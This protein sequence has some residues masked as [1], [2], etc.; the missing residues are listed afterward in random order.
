LPTDVEKVVPTAT[1]SESGIEFPTPQANT[2]G[3][4][5]ATSQLNPE[6][7]SNVNVTL[8][9]NADNPISD[10][11]RILEILSQLSELEECNLPKEE[12][13]LHRYDITNG[14]SGSHEYLAHLPGESASCDLQLLLKN[15]NGK[16]IPLRLFD[17]VDSTS[18]GFFAAMNADGELLSS[19]KEP[20][21]V[22]NLSNGAKTIGTGT[23]PYF[24]GYF[25][26]EYQR[27]FQLLKMN[28][29]GLGNGG[30]AGRFIEENGNQY[31]IL[32]MYAD[33]LNDTNTKLSLSSGE[34]V[35]LKTEKNLYWFDLKTERN[36]RSLT[37]YTT[38]DGQ[39]IRRESE[40]QLE[41]Y[42]ILPTN[43]AEALQIIEANKQ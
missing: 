21:P 26:D 39:M 37:E 7:Q 2:P 25:V 38:I 33:N 18:V 22:C 8:E 20:D 42:A 1:V 17:M 40:H 34:E 14:E 16:I 36:L 15:E 12:G 6:C 41:F 19:A 11:E 9:N 4:P 43:L 29:A 28:P 31:F 30:I 10:P 24:T 3:M 32:Q 23:T 5:V 13:W 27:R 35:S